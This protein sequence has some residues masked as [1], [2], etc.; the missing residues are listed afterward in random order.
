MG[1]HPKVNIACVQ[2]MVFGMGHGDEKRE[3]AEHDDNEAD[4][5]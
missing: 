3:N 1:F 2:S 5:E 4:H